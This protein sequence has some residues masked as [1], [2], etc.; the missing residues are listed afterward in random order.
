MLNHPTEIPNSLGP[1]EPDG[2]PVVFGCPLG[3]P[4]PAELL[5]GLFERYVF[6]MNITGFFNVKHSIL[7]VWICLSRG[8]R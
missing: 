4:T 7:I 8:H 5:E 2:R 1:E 3:I 6:D